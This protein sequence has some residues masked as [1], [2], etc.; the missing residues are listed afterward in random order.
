LTR[1]ATVLDLLRCFESQFEVVPTVNW[2]ECVEIESIGIEVMNQ[3]A[4]GEPVT[5]AA[6]KIRHFDVLNIKTQIYKT[7]YDY[8]STR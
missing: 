7:N 8:L 5:P 4:E 6:R 3:S 2:T 1:R